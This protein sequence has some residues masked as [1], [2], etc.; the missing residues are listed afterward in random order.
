MTGALTTTLCIIIQTV[1]A[2]QLIEPFFRL[3]CFSKGLVSLA[4]KV[5]LRPF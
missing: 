3:L 4:K 1:Q 2:L 5:M